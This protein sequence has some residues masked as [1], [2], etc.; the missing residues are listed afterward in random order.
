MTKKPIKK[1]RKNYLRS[2]RTMFIDMISDV[3]GMISSKR[4]IT[5]LSF[6]CV[7]VAFFANLLF[8]IAV[9]TYIFE[10]I[11]WL[12]A[13]GLGFT[14]AEKFTGRRQIDIPENPQA[15]TIINN[16]NIVPDIPVDSPSKQITFTEE[17]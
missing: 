15:D 17:T 11:L 4:V 8:A 13:A 16:P 14:M 2:F 5:L 3:D 6:F 1:K 9:A 12:T 10:G 7:F